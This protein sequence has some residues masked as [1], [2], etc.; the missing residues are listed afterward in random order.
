VY[1]KWFEETYN[2]PEESLRCPVCKTT[3]GYRLTDEVAEFHCD[4]CKATY[5]WYPHVNIPVA[6]LDKYKKSKKC[7]CGRCN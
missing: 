1:P 7:T 3:L 5:M 2:Q 6:E 4:D